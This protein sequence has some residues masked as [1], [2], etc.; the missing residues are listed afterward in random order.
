MS[1]GFLYFI[2][3]MSDWEIDRHCPLSICRHL[4][5]LWMKPLRLPTAVWTPL[6][7]VSSRPFTQWLPFSQRTEDCNCS[8]PL[9]LS[10]VIIPRI[11]RTLT[12]I[13]TELDEREREEFYRWKHFLFYL[14]NPKKIKLVFFQR[15]VSLIRHEIK[16][17]YWPPNFLSLKIFPPF[18]GW[19]RSKRRR[20]SSGKGQNWRSR[21]AWLSWV[22]SQSP[23]TCW[24]RRRTKTCC[25]SE[26]RQ[27]P[28]SP[29]ILFILCLWGR[30]YVSS[31]KWWK[32]FFCVLVCDDL[33]YCFSA[34]RYSVCFQI[35]H[36]TEPKCRHT[37]LLPAREPVHY[38]KII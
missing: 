4:L 29:I 21:P 31:C 15:S 14:F 36:C 16:S 17:M 37:W 5:S 23:P 28:T 32:L 20:S 19:R 10:A 26:G 33:F 8:S 18:P 1:A 12:Y 3:K 30:V 11:D 22:P 6:S 25:S 35:C 13:I 7:M 38:S 27:P 34:G 9:S 2:L 24:Q